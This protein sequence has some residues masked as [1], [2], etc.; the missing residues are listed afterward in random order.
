V[1]FGILYRIFAG[2][3]PLVVTFVTKRL[4]ERYGKTLEWS[5][6]SKLAGVPPLDSARLLIES[7]DLP[8]TP[9]EY[10]DKR[11]KFN[12]EEYF[13]EAEL[14]PGDVKSATTWN[15]GLTFKYL[16]EGPMCCANYTV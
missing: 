15:S 12:L 7:L 2:V 3:G 4:L 14:M 11:A 10:L 6:E 13:M 8:M 9:E 5:M 16:R 1:G